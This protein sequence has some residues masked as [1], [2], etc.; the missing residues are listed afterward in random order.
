MTIRFQCSVAEFS[1]VEA[2]VKE[3]PGVLSVAS[4]PEKKKKVCGVF[5][6]L[7]SDEAAAAASTI[8]RALR[9]VSFPAGKGE[10][11]PTIE[12]PSAVGKKDKR[13]PV[14]RKKT[15]EVES[16]FRFDPY[17]QQ[18]WTR[19]RER[20]DTN[21]PAHQPTS[22]SQGAD[23][24]DNNPQQRG[25]GRGGR[26]RHFGSGARGRAYFPRV[27]MIQGYVAVVDRVP[28]SA[29][30]DQIAQAF[31]AAGQIYDINRLENMAMLYFDT[32]EAVQRA[33]VLMNGKKLHTEI[34]TVSSGGVVRVPAVPPPPVIAPNCSPQVP[35]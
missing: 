35:P 4:M 26:G 31:S 24:A 29:T 18:Q 25:R 14:H 30:N 2:A 19:V 23:D 13:D 5:V 32:A 20:Q 10:G 12:E 6:Q 3:I 16:F 17:T 11:E 15:N 27:P 1:A 22:A 8:I 33:I 28:F 7:A 21:A 9:G 34:V